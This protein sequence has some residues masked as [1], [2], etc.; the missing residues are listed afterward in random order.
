[1]NELE[2]NAS[3]E[4]TVPAK[5]PWYHTGLLLRKSH[6]Y[7]MEVL[8]PEQTWFDATMKPFTAD[9]RL[10]PLGM[11]V[12]PFFRMPFVKWFALIGCI[13]EK[14]DTYFKIGLKR[15]PYTPE[16]DGELVCFA[17]DV[18]GFGRYDNNEGEMKFFITRIR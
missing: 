1:M 2:L 11:L 4:I 9:G 18:N 5:N 12:R 7:K 3:K 10:V 16:E 14:K 17:N 13:D 6:V 8:P 15:E